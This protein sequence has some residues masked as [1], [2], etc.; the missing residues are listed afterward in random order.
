M[1]VVQVNVHDAITLLEMGLLPANSIRTGEGATYLNARSGEM[2]IDL[3]TVAGRSDSIY[4]HEPLNVNLQPLKFM[5]FTLER[6]TQTALVSGENAL[7]VNIPSPLRY[8]LHKLIVMAER[9]EQFRTKVAKDAGQVDSIL[10]YAL[11][12]SRFVLKEAADDLM[13][14]G[15]GWRSRAAQGKRLLAHY[16]PSVAQAL[17]SVLD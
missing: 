4:R 11:A 7:I 8:A 6:T 3:L 2:R 1:I 16:H 14:R 10:S 13:S 12:R 5:E 17:D 9:E 15:K